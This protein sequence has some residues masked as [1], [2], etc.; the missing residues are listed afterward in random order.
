MHFCQP[1]LIDD[2]CC[3]THTT[4]HYAPPHPLSAYMLCAVGCRQGINLRRGRLS[5]G[6]SLLLKSGPHWLE[7]SPSALPL[8]IYRSSSSSSTAGGSVEA[9]AARGETNKAPPLQVG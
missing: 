9:G 7:A 4:P 1:P 5:A 6:Y 2:R 8:T 3:S